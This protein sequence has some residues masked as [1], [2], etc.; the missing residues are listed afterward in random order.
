MSQ[1]NKI[2]PPSDAA[3]L[4]ASVGALVRRF[5]L[6]ERADVTCCGMT[7]AQAATL[8]TLA[9]E[10]PLR[11][12]DLGRRLGIT[13][14]TLTRNLVRLEDRGLIERF[15]DPVDG[16]AAVAGLTPAGRDAARAVEEYEAR[17][18]ESVLEA[19]TPERRGSVVEG[20]G[21]LLAAVRQ[22]TETCCPGAYDHLAA[23]SDVQLCCP[24]L[25]S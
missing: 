2:N 16:R 14:S 19:I 6:S 15:P 21:E 13:P 23:P 4:R 5:S 9:V 25:K 20:L 17:F 10:G 24:E 7:V 22:V 3:R 1:A 11:L 18:A 8:E 12:G